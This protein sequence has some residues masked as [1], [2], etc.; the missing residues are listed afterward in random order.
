M[1]RILVVHHDIDYADLEVESLRRAGYQVTQCVGPAAAP[2]PCPALQGHRC[3]LADAAD[4]LVYDVWAN[5]GQGTKQL[6][7]TLRAQYPRKPV[8]LTSMGL[9]PDWVEFEEVEVVT[10]HAIPTKVRLQEAIERAMGHV[11]ALA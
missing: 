5:G 3:S 8:I 7:H 6:F 9:E 10:L 4:V 1:T 11:P 2:R